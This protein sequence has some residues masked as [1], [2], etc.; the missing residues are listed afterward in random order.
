MNFS[1]ISEYLRNFLYENLKMFFFGKKK[2]TFGICKKC[3]LIYQT[4]TVKPKEMKKYYDRMS[5]YYDNLYKPTEDK[6]K[7][8]NRHINIVK[9][10]LRIFPKLVLEVS[11]LNTYNLKQFKKNGAKRPKNRV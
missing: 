5:V 2:L 10:E 3:G 7:S 1:K 4:N 11:S 9:D 8:V 6:I